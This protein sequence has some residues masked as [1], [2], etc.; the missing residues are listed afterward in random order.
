MTNEEFKA[1]MLVASKW[2]EEPTGVYP[3]ESKKQYKTVKTPHGIG[4]ELIPQ[5]EFVS[6][7]TKF[8]DVNTV[9]MPDPSMLALGEVAGYVNALVPVILTQ[10]KNEDGKW[11]IEDGRH[12]VAAWRAAGYRQIPAVFMK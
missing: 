6:K 5:P 8:I 9:E 12:R 4:L 11:I 7:E 2:Q 10:K 1:L 3:W